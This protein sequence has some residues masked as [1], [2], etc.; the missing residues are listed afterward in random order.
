MRNETDFTYEREKYIL[1]NV[2][3]LGSCCYDNCENSIYARLSET[4]KLF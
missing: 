1:K 2:I 4:F 3:T